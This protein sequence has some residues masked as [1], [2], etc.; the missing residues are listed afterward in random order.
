MA[1]RAQHVVTSTFNSMR[2]DIIFLL[3][4]IPDGFLIQNRGAFFMASLEPT[5]EDVLRLDAE[6]IPPLKLFLDEQP[7]AKLFCV[8][9]GG[10]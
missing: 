2:R 10:D 4:G 5:L 6:K 3:R 7:K 9:L 1:R 8:G